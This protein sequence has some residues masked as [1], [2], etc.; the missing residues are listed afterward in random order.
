M[1]INYQVFPYAWG[2]DA[3]MKI[4]GISAGRH[5]GNSDIAEIE[6]K[7]KAELII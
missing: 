2:K 1:D 5:G 4:L 6:I 3:T 7:M